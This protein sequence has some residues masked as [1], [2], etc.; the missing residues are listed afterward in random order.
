MQM[1]PAQSSYT[2]LYQVPLDV[3]LD[4][5]RII[6]QNN[7]PHRLM[8]IDQNKYALHLEITLPDKYH[9]AGKNIEDILETYHRYRYGEEN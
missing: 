5:T 8:D 2:Q 1:I 4:I 7:L 6:L 9:Q 3:L